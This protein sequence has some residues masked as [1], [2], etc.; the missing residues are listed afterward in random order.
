[1]YLFLNGV[2]A[3]GCVVVA[4]V[5]YRMWKR[6]ED[7]LFIWFCVAFVLFA[8]ERFLLSWL[9]QPEEANAAI[10]LLRLC[11]FLCILVAIVSKNLERR[12]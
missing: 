7:R 3:G 6:T 5:F 8:L 4:A 2:A 9:N 11:A 12:S 1:M 10:Y